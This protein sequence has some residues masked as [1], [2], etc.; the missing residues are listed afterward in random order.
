M[1]PET[2][3]RI[4]PCLLE[5]A[6]GEAMDLIVEITAAAEKL[7]NRLRSQTAAN[8]ADLVRV[9]N[10]YY[11][12]L[13]ENHHTHPRDIE[14]ALRDDI[15]QPGPTRNLQLEARQHIL[16]QKKIDTWH[17]EGQLQD[18]VSTA[19]ICE[20][21]REFYQDMPPEMLN[22]EGAGRCFR[23]IPGELR[24]LSP[25]HDNVVGAHIPPTSEAVERF[26]AY[27]EKKYTNKALGSGQRILAIPAAH[28]RFNFIHPFPDG[29]GRVSRLM[30]HAMCL[31]A[32]IGAQGL[33]SIARGLARGLENKN[34]YKMWMQ[35]ADMPRQGD[36]D[37]RGNLS[38]RAL[39]EFTIW[40]LKICLDQIT[41]M[42]NLFDLQELTNRLQKYV[43]Q[44]D[45]RP[46]ADTL[47]LEIFHR[48]EITRG[49][50]ASITGL[51]ERT[52]RDLL[53]QLLENGIVGSDSPK[54]PVSLRFPSNATEIL[55][56]KLYPSN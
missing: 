8:L 3:S 17:Q 37:G 38:L 7:G 40:F 31:Q 1:T 2:P 19:F 27:F 34:E 32:G 49:E 28:H 12:N 21:H 20:L 53:A 11:S 44:H 14:R 52:S 47:L 33:W 5:A 6:H 39:E 22:I 15:D 36:L 10:C 54:G 55:F 25:L 23:M 24:S 29:N 26:M 16:L 35:H 48:G 43:A 42:G 45:W 9:M 13:I 50:T 51:K 18:P 30:S 46:E 4:E 41:F 56:P